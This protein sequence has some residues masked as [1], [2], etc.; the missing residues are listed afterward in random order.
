MAP[1]AEDLKVL[2]LTL[3]AVDNVG[4]NYAD[5]LMVSWP[6]QMM[7]SVLKVLEEQFHH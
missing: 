7:L 5:P 6:Y 2:M 4:K 1:R 3:N